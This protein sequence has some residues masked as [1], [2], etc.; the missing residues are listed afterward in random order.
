ML[1]G[2]VAL[3]IAVPGQRGTSVQLVDPGELLGWSPIINGG[4]MTATA[5]AVSHCRLAALSAD[6]LKRIWH[7]QPQY[8]VEFLRRV[9]KTIADRLQE[10]RREVGTHRHAL[11][12]LS[13]EEGGMA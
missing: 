7:E 9:G 8:G 1:A 5:R 4:P 3:E 11:Q 2:D 6:T 13:L 10:T 12:S